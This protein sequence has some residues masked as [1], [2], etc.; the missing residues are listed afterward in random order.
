MFVCWFIFWLIRSF[1]ILRDPAALSL[2]VLCRFTFYHK[3]LLLF[4]Q[5]VL[6][7]LRKSLNFLRLKEFFFFSIF[8]GNVFFS[9][10]LIRLTDLPP[11]FARSPSLPGNIIW[12]RLL[13][14]LISTRR[15]L[16]NGITRRVVFSVGDIKQFHRNL[17]SVASVVKR[18]G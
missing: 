10:H 8:T 15:K 18:E 3:I 5:V 9:G 13:S 4:V 2:A 17:A 11:P 1:Q 12:A 7:L 16:V 6:A 14:Y